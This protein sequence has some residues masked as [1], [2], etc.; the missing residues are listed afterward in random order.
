MHEAA[1]CALGDV[2]SRRNFGDRE[3]NV[4]VLGHVVDGK[5]DF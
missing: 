2:K 5:G 4:D 1:H 3:G